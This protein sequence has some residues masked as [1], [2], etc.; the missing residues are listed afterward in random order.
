[1]DFSEIIDILPKLFNLFVPG[2]IFLTI[3]KY[4]VE[5]KEKEFEITTVGSVVLSFIFQ[6]LVSWIVSLL[7]GSDTLSSVL[8]IIAAIISAIFVVLFRR[9][10]VFKSIIKYIGKVSGSK[11]IWYDFFDIEKGTRVR[12]FAKFNN[13]DSMIEGD[14][15][16]FE[17]LEDGECLFVITNFSVFC[18]VD[19]NA[20]LLFNN[21]DP[22]A[23][24]IFNTK[25]IYGFQAQYGK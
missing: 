14:I 24:M 12:F 23:S 2:F 19:G 17:T 15:K 11:K 22:S 4:F 1:M 8:A 5:T 6:L 21:R 3:Y 18:L 10:S 9:T 16:Y 20:T 25:S 7:K 13:G